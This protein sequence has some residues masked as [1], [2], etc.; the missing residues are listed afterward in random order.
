[1]DWG[2]GDRGRGDGRQGGDGGG[3]E[4]WCDILTG[5]SV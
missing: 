2:V 4:V 1:M 3:R 5:L